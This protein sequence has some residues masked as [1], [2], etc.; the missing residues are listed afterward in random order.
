MPIVDIYQ[1]KDI[2]DIGNAHCLF[3]KFHFEDWVLLC[4][5][6]ELHTLARSFAKDVGDNERPCMPLDHVAFY[7]NKYFLRQLNTRAY[8][9]NSVVEVI[10]IV[11]D[12][13]T[14]RDCHGHSTLDSLLPPEDVTPD[15][16]VRLTEQARRERTLKIEAGDENARL[17]F[18][19]ATFAAAMPQQQGGGGQRWGGY[20]DNK[21]K[22][23]DKGGK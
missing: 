17:K 20:N 22:G 1:V 19:A 23:G 11:K 13:V 4:L 7:Y 16:F 15:I 3:S 2:C 10:N 18:T 6:F 12:T 5:R 14:I 21:G 8:G 9:V